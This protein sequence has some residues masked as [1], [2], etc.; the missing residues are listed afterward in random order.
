[1]TLRRIIMI[2]SILLFVLLIAPA[3]NAQAAQ[4]IAFTR[5]PLNVSPGNYTS[6][7]I[8]PDHRLYGS[9][10]FGHIFHWAIQPNGQLSD[11]KM[12]PVLEGRVVIGL[13]FDPASTSDNPILWVT[14]N[15]GGLEDAP[16][17]TGAISKLTV[18]GYGTED[19]T[20]T[21]HPY[22]VGLPRSIRD[23]MVNGVAFGP[24]GALY[25]LS[26]SSS[27][28]GEMDAYWGNRPETLLSA[29]LLRVDTAA[30][31]RL[32]S[33]PL[34]VRTGVTDEDG[35]IIWE[36]NYGLG[37]PELADLYDPQAP[38][39]PVTLYATGMRNAYDL[40]WHS[41][42]QL[43]V[44]VNGSTKGA[45]AP[46]TPQP[47]PDSCNHRIDAAVFG[48]YTGPAIPRAEAIGEQSDLLLRIEAGKYY[49]HPNPTRCEWVLG[50]G[51]PTEN[52]D[53][54]Q[55]GSH[56]PV[57]TLPDR[58]W[59]GFAYD[60]GFNASA[61][62]VIEYRSDAFGGALRGKLMILRYSVGN[63]V[64]I[65][66]PGGP[67]QD[68]VSSQLGVIGLTDFRNPL[69]L[70]EDPTTGNLYVS[71]FGGRTITLVRPDE[72]GGAL[73]A[74]YMPL[75]RTAVMLGVGGLA[76]LGIL[77]VVGG[78]AYLLYQQRR[79]IRSGLVYA[80]V[81]GLAL[82]LVYALFL[83]GKASYK[84][85]RNAV[86]SYIPVQSMTAT[87]D[88][89][90]IA[91]A[92]EPTPVMIALTGNTDDP[93]WGQQIYN[94]TCVA[95]HGQDAHGIPNLGVNLVAS[96]FVQTQ[97][98]DALVD[99]IVSGRSLTDPANTTGI[100]MPPLGGNASLTREQVEGIVTYLRSLKT[101]E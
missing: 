15:W 20:W 2:L 54:G 83:T 47:L 3:D 68:I 11:E 52:L 14:D 62:G 39:A 10:L 81:T 77:A 95:C 57:G 6:L 75:G 42:G 18:T 58:N 44:P 37:A 71:E 69:D 5:E 91:E 63:D 9:T 27:G 74:S 97:P 4:N 23:H 30:L 60:L 72:S 41:N 84:A 59:A 48:A 45:N 49:G 93:T 43:Y 65:L 19:E 34:D 94:T 61:D 85:A 96:E 25:V 40:V 35:E 24:D 53:L 73:I 16:S 76:A 31:D 66:E 67:N 26:G 17:F 101:L 33:L 87:P 70:T 79:V 89:M 80:A 13:T 56:Y 7:A 1:M 8:S 88:G 86:T 36:Q 51:N 100:E 82:I 78:T 21:L 64:M 99:L 50:G 28:M 90:L 92:D 32:G 46:G 22:V 29:A 55:F 38:G 12:I 98:D